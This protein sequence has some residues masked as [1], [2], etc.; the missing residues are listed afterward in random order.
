MGRGVPH[1]WNQGKGQGLGSLEVEGPEPQDLELSL[2]LFSGVRAGPGVPGSGSHT[3]TRIGESVPAR[4]ERRLR[5]LWLETWT[6][7]P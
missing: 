1:G 4:E 6:C 2:E 5:A 7:R 3:E